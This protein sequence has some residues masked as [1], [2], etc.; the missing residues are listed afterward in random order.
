[1]D[2][3]EEILKKLISDEAAGM[4]N[5]EPSKWDDRMKNLEDVT[6]YLEEN[7][8]KIPEDDKTKIAGVLLS[9]EKRVDELKSSF[10]KILQ[11][12]PQHRSTRGRTRGQSGIMYTR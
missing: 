5:M 11:M 10:D 1:M 8:E 6:K 2:C 7:I 4:L 9:Y 12:F 3:S